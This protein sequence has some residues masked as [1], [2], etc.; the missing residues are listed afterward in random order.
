[1]RSEFL[2]G[3]PKSHLLDELARLP[4]D[5]IVLLTTVFRDGSGQAFVPRDLVPELTSAS[6]APVYAPYDTYIGRGI[7]GGHM[8]TFKSSGI[9]IADLALD[10]LAGRKPAIPGPRPSTASAYR[11]DWRQMKRWDLPEGNLPA[12]TVVLFKDP[13]FWEQH[14]ELVLGT[15]GAFA[16]QSAF[17][18]FL[19]IQMRRR[20]RAEN[21]LAE[22]EERMA[23]AA[24]SV[25]VGL[26]QYDRTSGTVWATDHCHAMFGMAATQQPT[27]EAFL[28]AIHPDD[29]R[30]ARRWMR[31]AAEARL[32]IIG[33]FRV[34]LKDDHVVWY[35]ARGQAGFDDHGN[36][37]GIS[38]TFSDITARKSAESEAELPAPD[39][40]ARH[41]RLRLGRAIG[42]N[43]PRDQSAAG[44]HPGERASGAAHARDA[45]A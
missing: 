25:N 26:W 7:V 43:R 24:A 33:E 44:G 39:A 18:A 41:A 14:R 30:A 22:S 23:F 34:V 38:G 11:V 40:G 1:M 36:A 45:T 35:L 4:R 28:Q 42:G 21:S 6:S 29:R 5:T 9:A 16:L 2:V 13:S 27:L 3:L 8:D 32:P 20:R 31:D 15:A 17:I 37:T 19:L 10:V 12:D